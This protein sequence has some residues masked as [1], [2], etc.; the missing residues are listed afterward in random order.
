MSRQTVTVEEAAEVLGLSISFTYRLIATKAIPAL[1]FG[2]KILITRK[3]IEDFLQNPADHTVG[4]D[5][6]NA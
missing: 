6:G 1:R 3:T 5:E 4:E 2:R